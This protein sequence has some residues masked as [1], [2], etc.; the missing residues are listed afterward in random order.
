MGFDDQKYFLLLLQSGG[1]KPLCAGADPQD[2]TLRALFAPSFH[3]DCCLTLIS[4]GGR[5]F[6]EWVVISNE[7]R[8]RS[9]GFWKISAAVIPSSGRNWRDRKSVV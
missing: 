4:V 9:D 5:A 7:A 1:L 6:L 2:W 3:K 8:V